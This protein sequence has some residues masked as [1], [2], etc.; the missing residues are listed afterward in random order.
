MYMHIYIYKAVVVYL[1]CQEHFV[2]QSFGSNFKTVKTAEAEADREKGPLQQF[3]QDLH[4]KR[5]CCC[6]V[7]PV[8]MDTK[9]VQVQNVKRCKSRLCFG[10][11]VFFGILSW[12]LHEESTYETDGLQVLTRGGAQCL[13]AWTA[14]YVFFTA[15]ALFSI[16]IDALVGDK[17][18][19]QQM[20]AVIKAEALL[21]FYDLLCNCCPFG[22]EHFFRRLPPSFLWT[23]WVNLII[24][25]SI[26]IQSG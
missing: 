9:L 2:R 7:Q 13:R 21:Y 23:I 25:S 14:A 16:D 26:S 17:L 19:R 5:H 22:S 20:I 1:H 10:F 24:S 3:C 6:V 8:W 18:L 15:Y 4:N 11:V 12:R